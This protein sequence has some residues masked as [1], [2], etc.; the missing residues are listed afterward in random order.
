MT[1]HIKIKLNYSFSFRKKGDIIAIK[2]DENGVPLDIYW[3][4]RFNDAKTDNCIEIVDEPVSSSSAPKKEKK[5]KENV[6]E[7]I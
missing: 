6:K 5:S 3:R 7:D 4:K 2:V 1:N